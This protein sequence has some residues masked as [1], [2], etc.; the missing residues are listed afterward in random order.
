MP[1]PRKLKLNC[2]TF[3][4]ILREFQEGP[5]SA[6]DLVALTGYGRHTITGY[7]R[8]LHQKSCIR[9]VG[10]ETDNAGRQRSPIYG[11]G[12]GKDVPRRKPLA[13]TI[14]NAR[15]RERRKMRELQE[16]LAA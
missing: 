2:L 5:T 6:T 4:L 8:T 13:Y 3:A 10:Y 12:E 11:L 16:R 1:N 15:Y 7:L 9:I 14:T